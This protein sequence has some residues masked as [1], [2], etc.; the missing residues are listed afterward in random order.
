MASSFRPQRLQIT[1]TF[2][3]TSANINTNGHQYYRSDAQY[4]LGSFVNA[5]VSV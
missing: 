5:I 3:F 2:K 4:A 1:T